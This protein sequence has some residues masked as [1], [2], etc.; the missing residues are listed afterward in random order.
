MARSL[1][2]TISTN[3]GTRYGGRMEIGTVPKLKPHH[4]SDPLAGMV[5]LGSTYSRKG[6]APVTQTSGYRT[7]RRASYKNK[8]PQAWISKGV[9]PRKFADRVASNLPTLISQVY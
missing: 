3:K 4:V 5:R 7:W 1:T 2:H 8:D 9:R 6:K